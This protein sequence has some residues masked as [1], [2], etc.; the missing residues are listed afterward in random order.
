MTQLKTLKDLN[1]LHKG[2]PIDKNHFSQHNFIDEYM[3]FCWTSQLKAEA[4]KWIKHFQKERRQLRLKN[5]P[6]EFT[7]RARMEA[8]AWCNAKINFILTFF[9]LDMGDMKDI[10]DEDLGL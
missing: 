10:T 2:T 7:H 4:I 3:E 9:D 5:Y 6:I 1:I 8:I